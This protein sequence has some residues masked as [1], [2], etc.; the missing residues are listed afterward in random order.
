MFTVYKQSEKIHDKQVIWQNKIHVAE[1]LSILPFWYSLVVYCISRRTIL[2]FMTFYWIPWLSLY[3]LQ[4]E[5]MLKNNSWTRILFSDVQRWSYSKGTLAWRMKTN[6]NAYGRLEA[7]QLSV[8]ATI[9]GDA[10]VVGV[11]LRMNFLSELQREY[12]T[13]LLNGIALMA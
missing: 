8:L 1:L 4:L 11:R 7:I 6:G 10:A 2:L 9:Y 12:N 5:Q 13:Q 3:N